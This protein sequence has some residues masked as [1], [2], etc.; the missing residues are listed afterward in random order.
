LRTR[1]LQV[2]VSHPTGWAYEARLSTGSP[3]SCFSDQGKSRTPTPQ[4]A[5]RSERRMSTSSI[6]W[7]CL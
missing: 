2:R 6:T 1:P 7:S 3:A 4:W 5:R